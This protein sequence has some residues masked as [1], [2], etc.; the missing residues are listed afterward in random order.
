MSFDIKL[1]ESSSYVAERIAKISFATFNSSS[2]YCFRASDVS[3]AFIF[4]FK[5]TIWAIISLI[6][7]YCSF[8]SFKDSFKSSNTNF[9][10]KASILLKVLYTLKADSWVNL[11]PSAV[12]VKFNVIP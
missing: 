4:L 11:N 8:D 9:A 12:L 7:L 6:S 2:Y 5:S 10:Y 3:G 1:K